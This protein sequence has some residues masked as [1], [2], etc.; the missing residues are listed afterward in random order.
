MTEKT[1]GSAQAH[2]SYTEWC[3]AYLIAIESG[4]LHAVRKNGGYYL[5]GGKTAEGMS[6]ED[7]ILQACMDAT[8]FDASVDDFVTDA[9]LYDDGTQGHSI[10]SLIHI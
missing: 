8:G 6:Y 10:L 4:T 2:L 5:L 9:D 1:F 7:T 3:G